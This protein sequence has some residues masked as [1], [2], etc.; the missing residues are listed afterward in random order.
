VCAATA[1]VGVRCVQGSGVTHLDLSGRSIGGDLD[2]AIAEIESLV[3]LDLSNNF[4]TGQIPAALGS[5][6][7]QGWRSRGVSDGLHGPYWLSSTTRRTT[8]TALSS[9]HDSSCVLTAK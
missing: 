9:A 1:G 7:R 5:M 8:T 4:I 6:P 3:E 2:P